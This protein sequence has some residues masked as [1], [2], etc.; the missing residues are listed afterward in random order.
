MVTLDAPPPAYDE[1]LSQIDLTLTADPSGT[2]VLIT[3][4]P[5]ADPIASASRE[6]KEQEKT[7]EN[8]PKAGRAPVD[9]VLAIDVSRSMK[10]RAPVPGEN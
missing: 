8:E 6:E 5:P 4:K 3:V 7:E 9:F 1:S 2:G 10:V